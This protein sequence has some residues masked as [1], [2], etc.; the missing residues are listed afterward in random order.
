M[1]SCDKGLLAKEAI[2]SVLCGYPTDLAF[3][4]RSQLAKSCPQLREKLNPNS[5]YLGYGTVGESDALYVYVQK[6]QIVIDI[7]L[8]ADR[9][10]ELRPLGFDVRPR[11]NYQA[12]AGWL[13]GLRV[14]HDTDR[15]EV[16]LRLAL[17]ALQGSEA[18]H[19]TR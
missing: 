7:R 11:N 10:G 8:P 5:R 1:L 3:H 14:P 15:P 16:I 2:A 19:G 6:K 13:T 18:D 17:E 4:L 9:A 12:K